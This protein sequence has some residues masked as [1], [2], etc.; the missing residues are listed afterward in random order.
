[1][2]KK[3]SRRSENQDLYIG[4]VRLHVLHHAA[5][6]PIFGLGIIRELSRH[7][8]R[9]GPGTIYPLLHGME[10]R[11]WLKSKLQLVAGRNRKVY[12]AT[13]AGR[14]ALV[15][16]RKQVQELYEEMGEGK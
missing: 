5:E 3:P 6:E 11:G 2:T 4:L 15:K 14:K 7:G 8:Y 1:M 16:A 12:L 9:L 10:R 13:A